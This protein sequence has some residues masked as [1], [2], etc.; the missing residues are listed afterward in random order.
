MV[1]MY[2]RRSL[3]VSI[4]KGAFT[5]IGYKVRGGNSNG[6]KLLLDIPEPIFLDII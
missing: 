2:E 5:V 3:F 1:Y 6:I 4:P